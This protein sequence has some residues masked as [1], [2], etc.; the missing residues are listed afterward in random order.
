MNALVQ[1]TRYSKSEYIDIIRGLDERKR[2]KIFEPQLPLEKMTK[3]R[4][5]NIVTNLSEPI[6]DCVKCG[7]CC[8]FALVVPLRS[9]EPADAADHWEIFADDT[10]D[11]PVIGKMLP[12]NMGTG[13][14]ENLNGKIGEEVGCAIY[15]KRLKACREFEAG[16]DRCHEYRRMYGIEP[17]LDASTAAEISDR[18]AGSENN[19]LITFAAIVV[20]W[21]STVVTASADGEDAVSKRSQLKIA[22]FVD[23]DETPYQIHSYDPSVETWFENDFLGMSVEDA[24]KMVSDAGS[25]GIN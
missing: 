12:R 14:C 7:A 23:K 3:W 1:I 8:S 25:K 21:I 10:P 4:S 17:Q 16:S 2:E 24:K 20:D 11:E 18:L 13:S 5:E 9:D 15:D 19:G 6:P 22:A